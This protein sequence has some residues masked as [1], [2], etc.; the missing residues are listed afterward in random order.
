MILIQI[1]KV[2]KTVSQN[3]L[4]FRGSNEK[5]YEKNNG[6][7]CQLIE[8]L[9]EL[10][11]IMKDHL[12]CVVD[13]EIQHHCLSHKIQNEIIILLSNEIKTKLIKKISKA[14]YFLVMLNCIPDIGHEKQMPII[15]RCVNIEDF[16]DAK[17]KVFFLGFIVV[18]DT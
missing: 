3:S 12:R 5:I 8:F 18:D 13:T 10:N 1:I 15:L 9:A 7:F 17:V 11:P 2:V 4:P 14:K 6:L 16:D